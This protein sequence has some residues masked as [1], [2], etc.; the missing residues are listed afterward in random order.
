MTG[1]PSNDFRM[2][3]LKDMNVDEIDQLCAE[4]HRRVQFIEQKVKEFKQYFV[5]YPEERTSIVFYEFQTVIDFLAGFSMSH[6][7]STIML[8]Q[9]KL[10]MRQKGDG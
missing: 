4:R 10:G 9:L 2:K 6:S 7:K 5:D 3:E 1:N 8:E